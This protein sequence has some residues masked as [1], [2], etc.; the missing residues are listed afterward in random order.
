M[1]LENYP[2]SNGFTQPS[3]SGI[4][5]EVDRVATEVFAPIRLK[6][7]ALPFYPSTDKTS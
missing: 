3:R 1:V 2:R 4:M 5:E 7:L 6:D